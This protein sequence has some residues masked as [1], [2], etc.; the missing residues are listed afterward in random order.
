MSFQN[1]FEK[2]ENALLKNMFIETYYKKYSNKE[3]SDSDKENE[4]KDSNKENMKIVK[5]DKCEM[6]KNDNDH[7][8]FQ[9][10]VDPES[11]RRKFIQICDDDMDKF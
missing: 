4:E 11:K 9:V 5:I 3:K 6:K 7:I 1:Y 2:F 8:Y 10:F